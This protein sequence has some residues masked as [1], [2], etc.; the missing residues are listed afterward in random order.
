[1]AT[2]GTTSSSGWSPSSWRT[3][4]IKQPVAYE[5]QAAVDRSTGKLR[6]LPPIVTPKEIWK[7][8]R[9][10]SEV[11]QGKAFLLQGG[12][13]AELFDYCNDQAIDTKVKLLLQMSLVLIWGGNKPVVRIARMAGQYAKPRSSPMET[14]DGKQMPSF[15]GDILNGYPSDQ[16]DIDP[17]RLVQAYFHSAATL[18][19]LRAQL[20]SG[21]ADLNNPLE[22]DL[23]HVGD[24]ELQQKY[25]RIVE[26]ISESLRFMRTVGAD[27]AGQLETVDLFTSHEGLLL[28]YEEAL[29]RKL[30]HPSNRNVAPRP[31]PAPKVSSL[32]GG[33]LVDPSI[34]E[35][36]EVTGYYNTSTHFLWVGD[37]TRQPDHAH[38]EYFRGIE[39]PIGIKVGP[40]TS[41]ADLAQL[42]DIV[43][44]RKEI[45][46]VTLITRY[47]EGK[48]DEL[49]PQHIKAV[50][51]TG[52]TVVWQCDPMHGNTRS[53]T[54]GIKTR[55]FASIFSEL[56]SALRIHKECGSF[57]GGVHLELTGDAVTECTGGSEGLQDED[58]GARYETFCDPRLN[59]KQALELAFL[60]AGSQRGEEP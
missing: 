60:V 27:T 28:E 41:T 6:R 2:N 29:T 43:N 52:H 36:A 20:A 19:Y 31:K 14:V 46:K 9:A 42:L 38:I 11:A 26:S 22:W 12:D 57:L 49:L 10:L 18:N 24:P 1:M 48:V 35:E 13:C 21:I 56:A 33:A 47:G 39:N 32:T 54:S 51:K 15:R 55:S 4:P 44:P 7:L 53:T 37:R 5:D 58:L 30:K 3:K 8:R 40:T 17:D 45:G 16:R 34:V 59:E 50:R 25:A 23:G